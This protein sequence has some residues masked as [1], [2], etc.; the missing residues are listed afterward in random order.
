M[1]AELI[2]QRME[3][4]RAAA[5]GAPE[6]LRLRGPLRPANG[7][8]HQV[9]TVHKNST[10]GLTGG[11]QCLGYASPN[12]AATTALEAIVERLARAVRRRGID[13]PAACPEHVDD[14]AD[15]PAAVDKP[16]TSVGGRR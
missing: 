6:R 10:G 1:A 15:H 12:A 2:A 8:G 7:G 13:P 5:S 4:G 11:G 14:P 9:S 16:H 3:L